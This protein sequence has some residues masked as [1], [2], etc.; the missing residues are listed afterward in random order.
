MK[1]E[2]RWSVTSQYPQ[3]NTTLIHSFIIII[4][5][6]IFNVEEDILV[7]FYV[8]IGNRIVLYIVIHNECSYFSLLL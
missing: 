1:E 8:E 4:N 5:F 3:K 2:T 6:N 7:S